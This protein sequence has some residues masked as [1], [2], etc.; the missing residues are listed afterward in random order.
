MRKTY[1]PE[2]SCR[3]LFTPTAP[4]GKAAEVRREITPW[5]PTAYEVVAKGP[6]GAEGLRD[7]GRDTATAPSPEIV[8]SV[9]SGHI[10]V[11]N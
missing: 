4:G 11:G 7:R 2:T 10:E 5:N 8:P 1:A 9:A 3:F 6:D